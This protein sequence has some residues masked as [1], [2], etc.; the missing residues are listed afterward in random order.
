[1]SGIPALSIIIPCRGDISGQCAL[2]KLLPQ[3]VSQKQVEIIVVSSRAD[4]ALQALCDQTGSQTLFM[5]EDRGVRMRCAAREAKSPNLWFLHADATLADGSIDAVINAFAEDVTG[6]YFRFRLTGKKNLRKR[7]IELGVWLRCHVGGIPY[8][9]Q[10]IFVTRS[11]YEAAGGH[12]SLPLFDEFRLVRRLMKQSKFQLLDMSIGVDPVR[13][14]Q[15]GYIRHVVKNR[16]M[17]MAYTLG[18][19]PRKLARWY[20][21]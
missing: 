13:W 4:A 12:E 6:G 15:N 8:G 17:S 20:Y 1:M 3:L 16:L 11:A 14:V 19:S 10:A 21:N 7:L 18:I 9:D 5:D 2:R